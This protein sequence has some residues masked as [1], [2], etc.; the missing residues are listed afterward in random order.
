VNVSTIL[1]AGLLER[2][3]CRFR[4]VKLSTTQR[5][6]RL[7]ASSN[8]GPGTCPSASESHRMVPAPQNLIPER[9]L[10]NGNPA[11]VVIAAQIEG[12]TFR[13][14]PVRAGGER[15]VVEKHDPEAARSK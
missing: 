15:L 7:E 3:Q 6:A 1:P 4:F 13:L 8:P 12:K 10:Q 14:L 5:I 11:C 2:V 9:G